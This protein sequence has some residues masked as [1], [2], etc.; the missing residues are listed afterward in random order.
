MKQVQGVMDAERKRC[1]SLLGDVMRRNSPNTD[2]LIRLKPP[3]GVCVCVGGLEWAGGHLQ[4][5]SLYVNKSYL[6]F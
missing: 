6:I 5:G 1:L 3:V 2:L 4:G